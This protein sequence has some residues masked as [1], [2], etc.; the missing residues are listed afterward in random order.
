MKKILSVILIFNALVANAQIVVVDYNNKPISFVHIIVNNSYF[1]TQTNLDGELL[2]GDIH[3]LNRNDTLLFRH[4]S[5]EPIFIRVDKLVNGDTIMLLERSYQLNEVNVSSNTQKTKYQLINSCYRS[6]QTS[7][8]TISH[9]TDGKVEYLSKRN[10]NRFDLYRKSS[11]SLVNK[12]L[13]DERRK[14]KTELLLEPGVPYPPMDCLPYQYSKKHALSYVQNESD[15][16]KT[17]IY[18][19]PG[20]RIGRLE[21]NENYTNYSILDNSFVGA[22]SLANTEIQRV[23]KEVFMIFKNDDNILASE[24]RNFDN[25]LYSKILLEYRIK[26]NK[27]D[28]YTRIFRVDEIFVED[29]LL[30]N[31]FEKGKYKHGYGMPKASDYKDNFWEKCDCVLY[32]PPIE[33]LTVNLDER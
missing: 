10:K 29:V 21:K 33:K 11:R 14:R 25:L 13:E 24:I 2:W 31:S 12:K 8:D 19:S 20:I 15:S 9:Y 27:D 3:Y 4:V 23:R 26:H 7:N 18:N 30:I 32:T 17:L 1:I 5:Y 16:S 28:V 22:N 6:Y